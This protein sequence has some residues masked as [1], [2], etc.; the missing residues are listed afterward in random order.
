MFIFDKKEDQDYRAEF[1][2]DVCQLVIND[3][4]GELLDA[5]KGIKKFVECHFDDN[6]T[7]IHD[8]I[9]TEIPLFALYELMEEFDLSDKEHKAALKRTL[10]ACKEYYNCNNYNEQEFYT[11]KF[12]KV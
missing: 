11:F 6:V 8:F 1:A 5:V 7:D 3:C 12:D 9:Y 10:I 4:K 2:N